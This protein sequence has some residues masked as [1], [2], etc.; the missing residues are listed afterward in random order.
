M[1]TQ[2][3]A[4]LVPKSLKLTECENQTFTIGKNKPLKASTQK[5]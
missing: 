4:G 1:E 2:N 5:E 3:I